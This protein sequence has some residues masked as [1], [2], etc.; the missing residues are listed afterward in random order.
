MKEDFDKEFH[1]SKFEDELVKL[2]NL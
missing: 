2:E 1:E